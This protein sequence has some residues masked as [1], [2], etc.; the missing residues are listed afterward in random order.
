VVWVGSPPCC[1]QDPVLR[2]TISKQGCATLFSLLWGEHIQVP[3]MVG[4]DVMQSGLLIFSSMPTQRK[5]LE[6]QRG[7]QTS[8]PSRLCSFRSAGWS[9]SVHLL[10]PAKSSR[11]LVIYN[12]QVFQSTRHLLLNPPLVGRLWSGHYIAN[13]IF[14][15]RC[16]MRMIW[17][18]LTKV[19][20]KLPLIMWSSEGDS[21]IL[22]ER[23][24]EGS[25][26]NS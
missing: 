13:S 20:L 9:L 15:D 16:S 5:V 18:F 3:V 22:R 25:Y 7:F 4:V 26:W 12:Y 23:S 8:G 10:L 11:A 14:F 19:E 17:N 24:G 21:L 1:W 2:K 6:D